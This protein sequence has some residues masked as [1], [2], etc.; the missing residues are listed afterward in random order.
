MKNN[1]YHSH[2]KYAQ[3]KTICGYFDLSDDYFKKRM[4]YKDE[5]NDPKKPFREGVH[6]FIPEH[7]SATKKAIIWDLALMEK[8]I[9]GEMSTQSASTNNTPVTN[10]ELRKLLDRTA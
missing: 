6:F 4:S 3:L 9:R 7:D 1:T 10:D 8:W 5:V 2:K